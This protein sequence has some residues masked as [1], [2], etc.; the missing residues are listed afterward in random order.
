MQVV[1][2]FDAREYAP[3]WSYQSFLERRLKVLKK[4]G[5]KLSEDAAKAVGLPEAMVWEANRHLEFYQKKVQ[6]ED[7]EGRMEKLEK[8]IAGELISALHPITLAHEGSFKPARCMLQISD[9]QCTMASLA[10]WQLQ[11]LHFHLLQVTG[12]IRYIVCRSSG[13]HSNRTR[14]YGQSLCSCL[15]DFNLTTE[16][17]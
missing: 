7:L 6:A 11:S 1:A 9:C 8:R 16:V 3:G 15:H 10:L 17:S 4:L 14:I 13:K 12:A 2:E 5:L